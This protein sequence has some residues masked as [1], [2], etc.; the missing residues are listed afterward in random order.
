MLAYPFQLLQCCLVTDGGGALILVS[1][2]R[3]RD[4]LQSLPLARTGGRSTCSAPARVSRP[5]W[6]PRRIPAEAAP[7]LRRLWT[8]SSK[9]P[10]I[11]PQGSHRSTWVSAASPRLRHHHPV[12]RTILTGAA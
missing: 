11:G 10:R 3:A 8:I 2:E 5:R 7:R 6:S 4:F 1:T 9:I 12:Q